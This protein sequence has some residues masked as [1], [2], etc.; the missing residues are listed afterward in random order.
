MKRFSRLLFILLAVMI[1]VTI[2]AQEARAES[3]FKIK[4]V[5]SDFKINSENAEVVYEFDFTNTGSAQ[6]D[7]IKLEIKKPDQ[8][9]IKTIEF[10]D[11]NNNEI[12]SADIQDDQYLLSLSDPLKAGEDMLL[13]VSC[14][15]DYIEPVSG[16]FGLSVQTPR[17]NGT[18]EFEQA[19]DVH[20]IKLELPN[21]WV[22]DS[23]FP[24]MRKSESLVE[25]TVYYSEQNSVIGLVKLNIATESS[26]ISSSTI[27][28]VAFLLIVIIFF[29]FVFI[30]VKKLN[31]KEG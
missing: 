8:L 20:K 1:V 9:D 24:V 27:M 3:S 16:K 4:D 23:S 13:R 10:Q 15:Y 18:V 21:D 5:T 26:G 19:Q 11:V 28:T 31:K 30:M 14:Q 25:T 6:L 12:L 22:L 2:G 29:A 17:I 7:Q